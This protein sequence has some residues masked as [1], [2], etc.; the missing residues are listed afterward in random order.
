[1]ISNSQSGEIAS[2]P[3]R[4]PPASQPVPAGVEPLTVADPL[5]VSTAVL[6]YE[7]FAFSVVARDRI[8]LLSVVAAHIVV[9]D[10]LLNIDGA[11]AALIKGV[12]FINLLLRPR[13]AQP[14]SPSKHKAICAGLGALAD[15]RFEGLRGSQADTAKLT[16]Q[17][18]DR[19]GFLQDVSRL[20]A[21]QGIN[22][23][24]FDGEGWPDL[25]ADSGQGEPM[26]RP[27][28]RLNLPT[29]SR[30]DRDALTARVAALGSRVRCSWN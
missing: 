19:P 11:R 30:V 25:G 20:F 17:G 28:F 10:P 5:T 3:F 26:C 23:R 18:A 9:V 12:A 15:V 21:E 1:M 4:S 7:T 8:G 16:L 24:R 2:D 14:W 22:V 13:T 27:T 6:G 29:H